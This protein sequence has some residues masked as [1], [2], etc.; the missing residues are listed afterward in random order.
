MEMK[1]LCY[2]IVYLMKYKKNCDHPVPIRALVNFERI[3]IFQYQFKNINFI[4]TSDSL[5]LTNNNG[6][7]VIYPG[8]HYFDITDGVMISTINYTVPTSSVNK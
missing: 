5:S 8:V 1:S 3:K 7:K 6:Q 2:I 4:I